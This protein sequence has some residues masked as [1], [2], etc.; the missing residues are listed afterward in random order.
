MWSD[1]IMVSCDVICAVRTKK[2]CGVPSH[3]RIVFI[4]CP[5][6]SLSQIKPSLKNICPEVRFSECCT[7]RDIHKKNVV[8]MFQYMLHVS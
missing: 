2:W 4:I 3:A 6:N 7:Y 1:E 5:N 8:N